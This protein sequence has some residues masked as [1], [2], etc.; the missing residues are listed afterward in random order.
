MVASEVSFQIVPQRPVLVPASE[1]YVAEHT[2]GHYLVSAAL[3][4]Y[5][6]RVSVAASW[7]NLQPAWTI[8]TAKS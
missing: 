1:P 6:G 5:L 2:L 8:L 7:T 3:K 4:R